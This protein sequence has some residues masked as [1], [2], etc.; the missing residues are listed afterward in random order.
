MASPQV[1]APG[2]QKTKAIER[3]RCPHPPWQNR[4]EAWW[5]EM[6]VMVSN[7]KG[8]LVVCWGFVGDEILPSYTGI[9]IVN[10]YNM[11]LKFNQLGCLG[12]IDGPGSSYSVVSSDSVTENKKNKDH[13]T[14]CAVLMRPCRQ[15]QET[16][17]SDLFRSLFF[18]LLWRASWS[19]ISVMNSL[20]KSSS[21]TPRSKR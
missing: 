19:M 17:L 1:T 14:M 12:L 21:Q 15:E 7:E 13:V 11:S 9:I 16:D 6:K 10:Q 8:H 4:Y 18:V 5:M 3:P 20:S 2:L